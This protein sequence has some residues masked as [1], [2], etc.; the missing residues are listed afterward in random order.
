MVANLSPECP[1]NA[2]LPA[3]YVV[4]CRVLPPETPSNFNGRRLGPPVRDA[5]AGG[6]N[7]LTPTIPVLLITTDINAIMLPPL[8]ALAAQVPHRYRVCR[9]ST[10][11]H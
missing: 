9:K 5:G 8:V 6:S 2:A 7:P 1:Q 11:S 4:G 3:A 10:H